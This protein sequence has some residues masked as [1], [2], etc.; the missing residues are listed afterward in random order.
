MSRRHRNLLVA[1]AIGVCCILAGFGLVG[2]WRDVTDSGPFRL[3]PPKATTIAALGVVP[4]PPTHDC[5]NG[6]WGRCFGYLGGWCQAP[7]ATYSVTGTVVSVRRAT[8]RPYYGWV[9]L[10]RDGDETVAGRFSQGA[11]HVRPGQRARV[12][13]VLYFPTPR[14]RDGGNLPNG[15]ELSPVLEIR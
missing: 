9:V 4:P 15:G 5:A 6:T 10:I 7:C 12:S 3:K 1:A 11:P 8:W 13:G 2:V 14:G